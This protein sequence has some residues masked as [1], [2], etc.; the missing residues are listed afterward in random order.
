M[1]SP[2]ILVIDEQKSSRDTIRAILAPDGFAVLEAADVA[3]GLRMLNQSSPDLILMDFN[4]KGKN[5]L[6]LALEV[7]ERLPHAPIVV[8]TE[9]RDSRIATQAMQRGIYGY[10]TRPVNA[11]DLR[12]MVRRALEDSQLKAELQSIKGQLEERVSLLTLMGSSD[13]VQHLLRLLEK[14]SPTGFTVLIEGE[15]GSGKELVAR[16]IHGMSSVRGG[17]FVAVDC[18]AIPEPLFES[19]L[20]GYVKG[21]FTGADTNKTGFFE[22]AD[23]GTLFLDEICNL[24]YSAQQKLLR[25][26]EERSIQRVGSTVSTPV[27][28]RIIAATNRSLEQEVEARQFRVDLLY[29][30]KEVSVRVPPLR[31]RQEDIC[32]LAQRFFEM[33]RADIGSACPG[34]SRGALRALT[35]YSWPGNVR[36][37][38]NVVRQA[39]LTAENHRP[40]S[41]SDL[42]L[43]GINAIVQPRLFGGAAPGADAF[44]PH[45]AHRADAVPVRQPKRAG[46]A[47]PDSAAPLDV[48]GPLGSAGVL[49]GAGPLDDAGAVDSAAAVDASRLSAG[50]PPSGPAAAGAA[51]CAAP[52]DRLPEGVSLA[53]YVGAYAASLERR[54]ILQVLE[55]TGG[56]KVRAAKR[57]GIDYKTLYRK[58]KQLCAEEQA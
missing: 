46:Q 31:E 19:E 58:L 57:L 41:E 27:S 42:P 16:A 50:D 15:S 25:A 23:K 24:S 9:G 44:P 53:Q 37:L 39:V 29:R 8:V 17:P 2:V 10:L 33:F 1:K 45:T 47:S 55:E 13:R 26:I 52:P 28:V 51:C 34:F 38:R 11:G 36:E 18:G 54:I 5:G 20:F 21:A 3:S 49:D 12:L 32:Y 40:I 56:N 22:A 7:Q 30:L 35:Q 6:E 4:L 14:I 43:Y 48:A